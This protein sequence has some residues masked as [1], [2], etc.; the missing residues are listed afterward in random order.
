M[1]GQSARILFPS[2]HRDPFVIAEIGVNHDGDP[3]RAL[4]LVDAAARTG[5]DAVK[6]QWFRA[7]SLLSKSAQLVT[8]QRD[9]GETDVEAML[10]RLELDAV[11]MGRILERAHAHGLA[12]IA[13]V[14]SPELVAE[15]ATLNWDLFKTASSD[16]VNR[17]LLE[18]LGRDGRPLIM[19]TGGSSLEEVGE[20]IGWVGGVPLGLLHCV[21]SYPT[22][23]EH[24]ALA[25]I[26]VL[27]ETFRLPVGYSDHTLG[28]ETGGLAV[29][30]GATMLEK[31]L[32][33]SRSANG[34]D[35]AS[36]LE[37]DSFKR[38][39]E[40]ARDARRMLGDSCKEVL[41][42][43]VPVREN[44]RQSVA[45]SRDLS[46]GALLGAEDLTTMRPGSGLPPALLPELMGRRLARDVKAG[47]LLQPED[48]CPAEVC[49]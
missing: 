8:Y 15:A 12:A 17:P 31:H 38:Y 19:S 29:A 41:Q 32:T 44:A 7:S 35:H 27:A 30:A 47:V 9:A 3:D 21:S 11:A 34:P 43:E 5:A 39:V 20:A 10:G 46:T 2:D 45:A 4:Q 37:P 6:V 22:P 13:T 23:V 1:S 18:A 16:L 36:S 40:F 25:G 26:G 24:T 48:L 33:W 14:F 28:W 49:S 42:I